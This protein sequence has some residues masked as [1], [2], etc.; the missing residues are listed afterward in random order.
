M[1]HA[2]SQ[3]P[4]TTHVSLCISRL[5][6]HHEAAQGDLLYGMLWQAAEERS[7]LQGTEMNSRNGSMLSQH[8]NRRNATKPLGAMVTAEFPSLQGGFYLSSLVIMDGEHLGA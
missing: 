8:H 4:L 1:G 3:G 2:Q 5:F 7:Q 6:S